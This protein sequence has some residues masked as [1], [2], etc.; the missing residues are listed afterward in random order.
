M[1]EAS[2]VCGGPNGKHYAN[3]PVLLKAEIIRLRAEVQTARATALEEAAKVAAGQLP[4]PEYY[5]PMLRLGYRSA[6][7]D[8]A[9]TIRALKEGK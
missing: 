3:C 5:D 9:A 7:R 8:I 1:S 4:A 2:C 6:G